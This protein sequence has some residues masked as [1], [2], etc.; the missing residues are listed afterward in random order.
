MVKKKEGEVEGGELGIEVA[1]EVTPEPEEMSALR[2]QLSELQTKLEV[3]EGEAKAHQRVAT[4]KG[5][6]LARQDERWGEVEAL[7]DQMK[8]LAAAIAQSQN[9][10]ED[11]FAEEIATKAP[12]LRLQF[13]QMQAQRK[14]EGFQKRV[15][16]L[17]LKQEDDTY[18]DVR[19]LVE[20]G[21]YERAEI[22]LKKLET[23]KAELQ[24]TTV[25]EPAKLTEDELEK[26]FLEKHGLLP[27]STGG[28]SSGG[29][30]FFTEADIADMAKLTLGS[31]EYKARLKELNEAYQEGR[32]TE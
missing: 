27:T 18:W 17:G 24:E 29:K 30:R 13:A 22:K 1:P 5:Q 4:E 26:K 16:V 23:Q 9:K 25:P 12:D 20:A 15:E 10:S 19:D 21:K 2:N 14:V 32:I 11:E 6:A 8:L 7:S 31:P 3:A 28:P